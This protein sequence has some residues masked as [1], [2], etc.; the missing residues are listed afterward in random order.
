M[1]GRENR[2]QDTDAVPGR[3]RT[4]A[5]LLGHDQAR[6]NPKTAYDSMRLESGK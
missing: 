3:G 5:K 4:C 6:R 1:K 2:G